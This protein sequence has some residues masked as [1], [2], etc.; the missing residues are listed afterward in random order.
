MAL[1]YRTTGSLCPAFAPARLVRLAVKP[2][3]AIALSVRC[4]TVPSGPSSSSVTLWEE[5]APVKL[6]TIH[7]PQPRSGVQVR[8]ATTPGWY[9]KVGST[10]ASAAASSS[11]SYPTQV[12]S[13]SN[14]K[15]QQ[16][17]TGSFP[18][19]AGRMHIHKHFNIA[20]PQ[21]ETVWP[22]LRHSCGSE[23]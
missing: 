7:G 10:A 19:A 15:L 8:T 2:A 20:E 18:L 13:Q 17:C 22:P 6:P 5:T 23:L 12:L 21:V 4:P 16:T 3:F 1:P 14:V 11:P 9:F